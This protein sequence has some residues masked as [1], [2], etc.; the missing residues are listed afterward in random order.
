[1][2]DVL[3]HRP[4]MPIRVVHII[5]ALHIGGAERNL[6]NLL[7]AMSC[8]YR[9][10]VFIGRIPT[11]RSFHDHLD[12]AVEQ[13]CIRIR[14][15]SLPIGIAKLARL[16]RQKRVN[17]V[18]THMFAASLYGGM[19]ARLAGVPAVVTSE[20]G[21]NP[22]KNPA[23][24]WFERRVISPLAD[25]RFCVSPRILELRRE[26]D[27]VPPGKL[28]LAINGTVVPP[29]PGSRPRNAVPL[30]GAVG[31]F[32]PA[33]DYPTLLKAVAEL[34]GRGRRLQLCILGDGPEMEHI[35][36]LVDTLQLTDVV[37]LP[38]LVSNT[39][40]WYER[41]DLC[42]SSSI[43]EG[44]PVALLEA[45]AHGLAVVATDVGAS[46]ETVANGEG[47]LV[48]PPRDPVA[49]ADAMARL[50]DDAGLREEMGRQAR[51]RVERE[52]SVD[53]AADFHQ[54]FYQRLLS[55][56]GVQQCNSTA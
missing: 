32:I 23:H 41:F 21:E 49:L 46:A 1:M 18:H 8:E 28:H 2:A 39:S 51:A 11:G 34:R 42:V 6:V 9:A 54:R 44:Q 3:H 31:R 29:W 19:A 16:L 15:R 33:K 26:L 30:I 50:L 35:R 4:D 52:Y 38:G 13:H 20:H 40:E 5:P 48:V 22:W 37:Q 17:V 14:R 45:M 27:G 10:A 36:R 47:G 56:N 24:R 12:P 53:V 55:A 43:R 7:N 25:A